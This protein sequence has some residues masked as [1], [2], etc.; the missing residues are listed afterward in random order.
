VTLGSGWGAIVTGL[1]GSSILKVAIPKGYVNSFFLIHFFLFS[2]LLRGPSV[3]LGTFVLPALYGSKYYYHDYNI[4][5]IIVSGKKITPSGFS[6]C[7]TRPC[8]SSTRRESNPK[9]PFVQHCSRQSTIC[10]A[11]R[12]NNNRTHDREL[13]PTIV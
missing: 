9:I 5:I 12:E 8:Q 7:F 2:L 4:I 13:I 1:E 3:S 10:M 6:L 11:L